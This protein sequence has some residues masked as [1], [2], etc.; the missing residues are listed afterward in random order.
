MDGCASNDQT[1]QDALYDIFENMTF[2][3]EDDHIVIQDL[4]Q[5]GTFEEKGVLTNN[6]GI[7]LRL[8]DGREFQISIVQSR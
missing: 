6:K 8:Q 1:I 7:V 2:P 3:D 5:V 4:D